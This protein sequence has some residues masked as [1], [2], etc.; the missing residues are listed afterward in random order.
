M[1]TAK[2]CP[3]CDGTA[4][5]PHHSERDCFTAID[6]EIKAAL[7]HLRSL[8]KRKSALL[9]ARIHNRQRLVVGRRRER[10]I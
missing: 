3:H 2:P 4:D 6:R 10:R 1:K 5:L 9:R 7:A 8:T